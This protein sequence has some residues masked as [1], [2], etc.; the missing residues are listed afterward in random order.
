[1][2]SLKI[3]GGVLIL[4]GGIYVVYKTKW[5]QKMGEGLSNTGSKIKESF[6]EGYAEVVETT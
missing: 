6:I 2:A 4:A 3:V 1:M 5:F